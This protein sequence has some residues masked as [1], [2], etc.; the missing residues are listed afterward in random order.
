MPAKSRWVPARAAV[1]AWLASVRPRRADLKADTLAALPGTISSVPEGMAVSVL[2][3]VNSVHGRY[4]SFAAPIAGGLTA[5]TLLLV[6]AT[7]SGT[8]LAAGSALEDVVEEQRPVALILLTL[9]AGLIM[10]GAAIVHVGRY[11]RFVS[12]RLR[13]LF[14]LVGS[15]RDLGGP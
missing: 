5:G 2:A 12:H 1:E 14:R 10:V 9:L 8:A 3:G 4:A 7:T 13:T 6:F 11:F 15:Q